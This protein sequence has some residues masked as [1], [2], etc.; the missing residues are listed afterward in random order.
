[1]PAVTPK[2]PSIWNGRV[3]VEEVGVDA[4]PAPVVRTR[5]LDEAEQVADQAV[6]PV[7]VAEAG[8]EVHLPGHRPAGAVVP[9]QLERAAH[10]LGQRGRLRG[11]D[12]AARV[13]ADE[14]GQ[15]AV[16]RLRLVEVLAPLLELAAAA[17]PVRG[18]P[19]E[20]TL[21]LAAQLRV[22]ADDLRGLD[23]VREELAQDR[24]VG[25]RR[26]GNLGLDAV[27]GAELVLRREGRRGGEATLAVGD[28]PVERELGSAPEERPGEV[29]EPPLVAR[30]RVVLPQVHRVPGRAHRPVGPLRVALAPVA[31]R[32]RLPPEVGVVVGDPS[33]R[34]VVDARGLAGRCARARRSSAA[35]ARGTRRGSSPP[36]ASSSSRC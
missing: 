1:M 29:A 22:P 14:V 18:E 13:E 30:E 2:L 21:H 6:G 23:G 15:V 31:D 8:P 4:A 25:G 34:A 36:P 33:A 12:A 28:E 11:G 26:R 19:G 35:S 27:R 9:S 10:R 24:H 16:V 32:R 3:G 17:D 20:R 7:P 5:R